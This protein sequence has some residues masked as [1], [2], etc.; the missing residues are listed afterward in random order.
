[1]PSFGTL[2]QLFKIS[3]FSAH[4]W[5]SRGSPRFFSGRK[6]RSSERGE[7]NNAINYGHLSADRWRTHSAQTNMFLK[8]SASRSLWNL[9]GIVAPSNPQENL[10]GSHTSWSI[11]I[12]ELENES[13]PNKPT[14][15]RDRKDM[16]CMSAVQ[17]CVSSILRAY[18]NVVGSKYG[19]CGGKE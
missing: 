18:W 16:R 3:P 11:W 13:P 4:K 5:H 19:A 1:M 7:K 9:K 15:D 6:V 2:G 10:A 17:E 14:R 12:Y 8:I